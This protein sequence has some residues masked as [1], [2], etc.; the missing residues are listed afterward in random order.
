[1]R[2]RIS[3]L[4][5]FTWRDGQMVVDDPVRHRQFALS[6]HA[7]RLL[8]RFANWTD[9]PET[10][11]GGNSAVARQLLDAHVLVAEGSAEHLGEEN[12]GAWAE[13]GTAATYYHLATR[14]HRDEK[15]ATGAEDTDWLV[16][17][18]AA[19]PQPPEIKEYPQA[20]RIALPAG[21]TPLPVSL[22]QVLRTR[23]TTRRLQ[24]GTPVSGDQLATLLR[25][26]AGPVHQVQRPDFR[27][28]MLKASPSPGALHTVEVYPV[29]RNVTGVEPGIYHYHCVRHDLELV[30][31]GAVD[32][33]LLLDWCGGQTHM[34]HAGAVLLYTARLDRMAWKYQTGSAYR[35][36]FMELGHFSQTAYLVGTALGLGMCFTAATRDE[37]IEEALGLDWTQEILLGVSA[38]GIPEPGEAA[39]QKVMLAGGEADFSFAGDSWDGRGP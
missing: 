2:L 9:F 32:D 1:M 22:E 5:V 30:V 33:D 24:P 16:E 38:V 18:L 6:P 23:R 13:W 19:R 34:R 4:C 28:F 14:N 12:L 36:V 25:W 37:A 10:G 31:P 7:Q 15:F 20:A 35:S 29:V 26:V 11:E 3:R 21:C 8:H 39:R 27:P 17:N